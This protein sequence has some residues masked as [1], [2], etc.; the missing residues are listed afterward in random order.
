MANSGKLGKAE[1][2][3]RGQ[4]IAVSSPLAPCMDAPDSAACATRV[5]EMKN[6][7][8]I[9]DQA[10]G[11]QISGWLDAWTP[12]PSAYAVAGA[13]RGRRRRG[14]FRAREQSAP[15]GQGRRP[16]LPGHVERRRFAA[17]LDARDERRHPAR[18]FRAAGM[19]DTL[20]RPAVTLEA[21]AVWI[22]LYDAVTTRAAAMSRAAAAP[23]SAS[24]D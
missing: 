13:H 6:P 8:Y 15:R 16:Q 9:G 24:R 10:G 11:T 12:A 20:P 3:G 19:F 22:H 4:L 1:A 18:R 21:G 17:D 5:E 7:Y 23:T 14:Q 2:A